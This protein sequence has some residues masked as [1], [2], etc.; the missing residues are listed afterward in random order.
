MLYVLLQSL[1]LNHTIRHQIYGVIESELT[2][3][4]IL[5]QIGEDISDLVLNLILIAGLQAS[6]EGRLPK[7]LSVRQGSAGFILLNGNV[8]FPWDGSVPS[9]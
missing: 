7:G 3:Q 6:V 2:R 4:R 8:S 5:D 9:I 1:T